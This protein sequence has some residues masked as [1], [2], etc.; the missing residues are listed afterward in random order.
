[1]NIK[2]KNSSHVRHSVRNFVFESVVKVH[3]KETHEYSLTSLYLAQ[4]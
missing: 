4:T 1:M 2:M 3:Q